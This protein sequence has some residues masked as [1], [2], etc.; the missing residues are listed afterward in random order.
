MEINTS[1]ITGISE[2]QY[3]DEA[4]RILR[5]S[6][7][8]VPLQKIDMSNIDD[9][10]LEKGE[11]KEIPWQI[12]RF[13]EKN[14][15]S[16]RSRESDIYH[17]RVDSSSN[18]YIYAVNNGSVKTNKH[19]MLGTF[20]K[21]TSES[22]KLITVLNKFGHIASYPVLEELETAA[23]YTSLKKSSIIPAG[24]VCNKY[25]T[26]LT[27]VAIDNYDL[28]FERKVRP[29]KNTV[30][31]TVG[32]VV[33][34]ILPGDEDFEEGEI[35]DVS[36]EIPFSLH[37]HI[38]T[39]RDDV[40][41]TDAIDMNFDNYEEEISSDEPVQKKRKIYKFEPVLKEFESIDKQLKWHKKLLPSSSF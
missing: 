15:K 29:G 26:R 27:R 17:L 35:I 23:A 18:D 28:K 41:L 8:N 30:H 37:A 25:Y 16:E 20:I 34:T 7:L 9:I 38:E 19:I 39:F 21:S 31:D 13:Y 11:V 33:Q 36:E 1:L 5:K 22:C 3:I 40:T 14:Y 6:A 32:I 24:I 12:F 10:A 4:A 2:R